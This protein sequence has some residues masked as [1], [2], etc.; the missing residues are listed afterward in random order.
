LTTA[1]NGFAIKLKQKRRGLW[2]KARTAQ[3]KEAGRHFFGSRTI[4]LEN[5]GQKPAYICYCE[6]DPTKTAVYTCL[7]KISSEHTF[8]IA[9]ALKGN[10]ELPTNLKKIILI[11]NI[12]NPNVVIYKPTVIGNGTYTPVPTSGKMTILEF[13]E[14]EELEELEEPKNREI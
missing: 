5:K 9:D 14:L 2:R 12:N 4:C 11:Q 10:M 6:F 1:T 13:T 8:T 7:K 3:L